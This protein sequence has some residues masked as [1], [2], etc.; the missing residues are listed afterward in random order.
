[1]IVVTGMHRS[2]TSL[3]ALILREMGAD[4]GPESAMYRA[5]D[6][7]AHGYL[8]R[9]DVV[10]MNSRAI[11]GFTRTTGRVSQIASQVSYLT[12]SILGTDSVLPRHDVSVAMRGMGDEL[13]GTFVKDPRFCLTYGAWKEITS[14][15]GLV[16]ALRHP[17]ASVASLQRRNRIPAAVGYKF[18]RWHMTAI[19]RAIDADTLVLRQEELIGDRFDESIDRAQRWLALRGLNAVGDP[20]GVIDQSLVHHQPDDARLPADVFDVWQRLNDLESFS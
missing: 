15:G 4:F 17:S 14:V 9:S 16:V 3:A 18:W 12:R 2:G 1:M 8:E 5:D 11:T 6:W 19:M 7:N 20:G 10:D 13:R